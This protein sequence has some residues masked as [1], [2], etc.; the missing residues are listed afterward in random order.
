[1]KVKI[2]DYYPQNHF[3]H[4]HG[5][6]FQLQFVDFNSRPLST[7]VDTNIVNKLHSNYKLDA[8]AVKRETAP[9]SKMH[10][11]SAHK[12]LCSILR[13]YISTT[14]GFKSATRFNK[15]FKPSSGTI[16]PG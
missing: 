9:R 15:P 1:M 13:K 2:P 10:P 12:N 4:V 8:K 11:I 6:S 5:G 16:F 7:A 3:I 14:L